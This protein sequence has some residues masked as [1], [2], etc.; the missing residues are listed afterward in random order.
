M[1]LLDQSQNKGY[2]QRSIGDYSYSVHKRETPFGVL[3]RVYKPVIATTSW[4]LLIL[5]LS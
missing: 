2:F 3:Y 5:H 1:S 4:R